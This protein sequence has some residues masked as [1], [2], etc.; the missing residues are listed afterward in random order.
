MNRDTFHLRQVIV[1]IFRRTS[2]IGPLVL[3]FTCFFR[4]DVDKFVFVKKGKP[5]RS[6]QGVTDLCLCAVFEIFQNTQ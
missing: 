1:G 5:E 6:Y 2:W 4:Y 3:A